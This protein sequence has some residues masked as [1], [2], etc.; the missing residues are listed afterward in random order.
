MS[1]KIDTE[2]ELATPEQIAH[3]GK[4]FDA[5][6]KVPM[7]TDDDLTGLADDFPEDK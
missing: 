1:S 2:N 5:L 6:K 3:L 4:L 7:T